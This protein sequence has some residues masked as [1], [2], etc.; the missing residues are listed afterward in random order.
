MSQTTTVTAATTPTRYVDV[1]GTRFSYRELGPASGVPLLFLHHFTATIDDWDPRVLDGIA[2]KRRIITFDNRGVGGS[3]GTV[4]TSV[5]TM[6]DDAIAFI[7]ALG[8]QQ[9]DLLGFS[10]GGFVSQ[11]IVAKAPDL[12]RK[13]ILAGTGPAGFEGVGR[14]NRRLLTDAL[15]GATTLRDPKPL[16]FFTRTKNGRAAANA[17][18]T[19]LTER[20]TDRVEKTSIRAA[21]T[22]LLAIARWGVQPPMDLSLISQPALVANGEDDRMLASRGSFDLAHRLPNAQLVIYPDAGHGG[23]FQYHEKFVPTVIEFLK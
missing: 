21:V 8:H 23:V 16:L 18:M 20:S 19:R 7:R 3:G 5:E 22:Q 13:V 6:A 2:A 17:Y 9:V 1:D 11:I 4:P 14:F 10:L 15:R 12:V